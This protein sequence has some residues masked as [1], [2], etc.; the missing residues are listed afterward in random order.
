MVDPEIIQPVNLETYDNVDIVDVVFNIS[1][2]L[3]LD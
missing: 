2:L 3:G 1:L